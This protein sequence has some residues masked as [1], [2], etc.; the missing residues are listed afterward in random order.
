[1]T[2]SES[3]LGIN[4][5]C[6]E[7]FQFALHHSAEGSTALEYCRSRGMDKR[8]MDWLRL[9]FCPSSMP[10]IKLR[11]KLRAGGF[12]ESHLME[13][14]IWK[15]RPDGKPSPS[16]MYRITIPIMSEDGSVAAFTARSIREG[17]QPRYLNSDTTVL[18]RKGEE[19]YNIDRARPASRLET[20]VV[21]VEGCIKAEAV[22]RVGR[23][24]V[25]ATQGTALTESQC[26]IL[27]GM[28]HEVVLAYDDDKAGVSARDKAIPMLLSQG[29]DVKIAKIVG[30]GPDDMLASKGAPALVAALK[31]AVSWNMQEVMA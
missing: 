9:G 7:F 20:S 6:Q 26:Y 16:L 25:V 3:I 23:K 11:D 14:G 24:C 17:Q 27:A 31:G 28:S 19:L 4:S 2:Q 21:L 8:K 1:M 13:S 30:G 22:D 29:I 10:C 5:I 12:S 15:V 18:Y